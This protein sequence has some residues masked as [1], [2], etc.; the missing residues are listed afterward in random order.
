MSTVNRL[1]LFFGFPNNYLL[2]SPGSDKICAIYAVNIEPFLAMSV[3]GVNVGPLN[4]IPHLESS[5]G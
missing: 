5:V 3:E 4:G 2:I 1:C